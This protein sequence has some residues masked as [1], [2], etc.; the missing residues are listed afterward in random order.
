MGRP[1][2]AHLDLHVAVNFTERAKLPRDPRI[3]EQLEV[4]HKILD[5][6]K[7]RYAND[8]DGEL[9]DRMAQYDGFGFTV[10]ERALLF[11]A[12]IRP[13]YGAAKIAMKRVNDVRR[14]I[15]VSKT[16]DHYEMEQCHRCWK[17]KSEATTLLVCSACKTVL[18]CSKECQKAAWPAHKEH[19]KRD[20]AANETMR[21]V[22]VSVNPTTNVS[23]PDQPTNYFDLLIAL[24]AWTTKH[25]PLLA[26]QLISALDLRGDSTN[27]ARRTMVV[28]V[29]W[30]PGNVPTARRFRMI[31]AAAV[32]MME[33]EGQR[34]GLIETQARMDAE[35]RQ[36]GGF[37]VAMMNILCLTAF[38]SVINA[39]PVYLAKGVNLLPRN[40]EWYSS[41]AS[42]LG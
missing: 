26:E 6:Y 13:W 37:G 23:L 24:R 36:Q 30:R 22:T 16:R 29:E 39:A 20:A 27:R 35:H 11:E 7:A 33:V 2:D 8:P 21:S 32:D 10:Y 14:D 12:G 3:D 38:P 41:L 17:S 42:K 4:V 31:S 9:R 25:R 34:P 28:Y 40:E 1:E 18:Y 19:C 5:D 15:K